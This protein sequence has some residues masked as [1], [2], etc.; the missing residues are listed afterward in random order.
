MDA[1]R[2]PKL[3]DADVSGRRFPLDMLEKEGRCIVLAAN[4]PCRFLGPD[5]HC[6]IYPTRPNACVAFQ[7]GD[8]QC[9]EARREKAL[10]SL[11]PLAEPKA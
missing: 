11:L 7:A 10:P 2:E 9:Q 5:N 1:L 6:G 3:L 8:E 4:H